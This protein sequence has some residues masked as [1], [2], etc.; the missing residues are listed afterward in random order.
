[1][2]SYDAPFPRPDG[3]PPPPGPAQRLVA[4]AGFSV[5]EGGSSIFSEPVLVYLSKRVRRWP[6]F[7]V[8]DY[9]DRPLAITRKAGNPGPLALNGTTA[10]HDMGGAPLVTIAPESKLFRHNYLVSGVANGLYT[11]STIGSRELT[12]EANNE[13][14][15]YISGQ[16][17]KGLGGRNLTVFDHNR[18]E[19]AAI[20]V[21]V[22]SRSL[23]HRTISH[24]ISIDPNLSGELRRL[25]VAAPVVIEGVRR[26]QEGAS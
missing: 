24:V 1:M 22:E 3:V 20:R 23:I 6:D 21:F 9:I 13:P 19:V 15:G 16:G 14:F 12:I 17:F 5:Y 10:L 7:E 11:M 25:L 18:Q 8:F 2:V 26:S 4:K